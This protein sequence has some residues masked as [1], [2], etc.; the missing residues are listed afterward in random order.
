MII[1]AL[2]KRYADTG[3]GLPGWQ[4]RFVDYAV[5]IDAD[6]N[7]LSIIPLEQQ[8]GKKRIRRAFILPE[9][10]TGRTS[11]IRAAFLCDNGG[12]F[13]GIDPKRGKIKFEASAVLHNTVLRETATIAA[14]AIKAFFKEAKPPD[15]L[16]ENGNYIFMV[17]GKFAHEDVEI[18]KAW[19]SYKAAESEGEIIRCLITGEQDN[20]TEL[21][22]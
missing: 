7:V 1:Q 10:P 14:E 12:Y 18:C 4:K 11:G 5:N 20:L 6:G 17:D 15:E 2:V 8:D 19:D 3:G 13:F 22:G 21:H 9:E 16:A